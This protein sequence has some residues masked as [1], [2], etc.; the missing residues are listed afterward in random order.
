MIV[1]GIDV[2][3][4][5]TK[6]VILKDGEVVGKGIA[7]TGVE[8]KE[9]IEEA[10]AEAIK[11][12]GISRSDIERIGATG[13]GGKV[14]DFADNKE[15]QDVVADAAGVHFLFP[16]AKTVIDVGGEESRGIKVDERGKV[17]DFALNERCAAGAGA[18]V[19]AMARALEVKTEE[20]GELSL[21]ST[22]DIEINAQCTIFAESEVVSQ[23]H[24]KTT[25]PD[26]ARA[27]HEGMATRIVSMARRA[28]IEGEVALIGGVAYNSG[29]VDRMKRH[30]G[31]D[32]LISEDPQI[33][34]AIGAATIVASGL[35]GELKAPPPKLDTEK[36]WR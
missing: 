1:A 5:A 23:I 17:A 8:Q 18:F 36:E 26:I 19:E 35:E 34:G 20:M 33:V 6:A 24:A 22:Q 27:V 14:V 28:G 7:T 15:I 11:N 31:K 30:I 9:A 2:G 3:A 29:F 12:A 13:A 25:K 32:L 21:K 10:L 16:Q 4:V